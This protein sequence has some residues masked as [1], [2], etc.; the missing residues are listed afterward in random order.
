MNVTFLLD[1]MRYTFIIVKTAFCIWT[2]VLFQSKGKG[3]PTTGH[4]GPERKWRYS[5]T[6][7]LTSALDR[8]GWSTP[9]SGRCTS[10][11]D[12]IPVV[13]EAVWKAGAVWTRAENLAHHGDSIT[14]PSSPYRVTVPSELSRPT[15]CLVHSFCSVL[16]IRSSTRHVLRPV[17]RC[18]PYWYYTR[19]QRC[20]LI[21]DGTGIKLH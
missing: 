8:G 2:R 14:G 6:L 19:Q 17:C 10:E 15:F 21:R 4:E 7:S 5:C 18:S 13:Q 16:L 1:V 3:H 20:T 9:R 11:K 12:P